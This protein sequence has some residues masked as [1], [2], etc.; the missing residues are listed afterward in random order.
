MGEADSAYQSQ[1]GRLQRYNA[2]YL[3]DVDDG[4]SERKRWF[5][6]RTGR[7]YSCGD[8][9]S[10]LALLRSQSL[11]IGRWISRTRPCANSEQT[12]RVWL[13]G[14][15]GHLR[16]CGQRRYRGWNGR[17]IREHDALVSGDRSTVS[18]VC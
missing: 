7:R 12:M 3:A 4:W 2:G 11:R 16:Q 10:T 6:R 13:D 18:C 8:V 17:R 9:P 5:R 1:E 15:Q 14:Y